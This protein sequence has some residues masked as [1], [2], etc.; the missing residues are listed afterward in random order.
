M[1]LHPVLPL[2]LRFLFS[3]YPC[4][5]IEIHDAV[6]SVRVASLVTSI[7]MHKF[8]GYDVECIFPLALHFCHHVVGGRGDLQFPVAS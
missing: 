4:I 7:M 3:C 2:P 6:K 1:V 5:F 8:I